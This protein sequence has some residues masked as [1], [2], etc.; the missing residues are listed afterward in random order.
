M[1]LVIEKGKKSKIVYCVA[2][3]LVIIAIKPHA[4]CYSRLPQHTDT[5]SVEK[6]GGCLRP[7]I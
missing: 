1:L 7:I 3:F 5:V 2:L 4:T 6:K